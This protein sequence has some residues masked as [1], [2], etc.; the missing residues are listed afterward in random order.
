MAQKLPIIYRMEFNM[1]QI[2]GSHAYQFPLLESLHPIG[3]R[4]YGRFTMKKLC[5]ILCLLFSAGTLFGQQQSDL[6]VQLAQLQ[7]ELHNYKVLYKAADAKADSLTVYISNVVKEWRKLDNGIKKSTII[8]QKAI[9]DNEK[10]NYAELI[11]T[12]WDLTLPDSTATKPNNK[13]KKDKKR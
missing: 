2:F 11:R 6:K 13:A 5:I 3:S 10:P 4:Y 7:L 9:T 1:N 8:L 12:G